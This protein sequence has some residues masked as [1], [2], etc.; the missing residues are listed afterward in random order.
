MAEGVSTSRQQ[1]PSA[2]GGHLEATKQS[3]GRILLEWGHVNV[4]SGTNRVTG[5]VLEKMEQGKG[6]W[7]A[8]G[9]IPP[10]KRSYM[11]ER[12]TPDTTTHYRISAENLYG[13]GQP[14]ETSA[15]VSAGSL[16]KFLHMFKYDWN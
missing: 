14:L 7:I 6:R 3:G 15:G 12:V 4:G 8:L 11:V 10:N 2:I 13:K 16:G 9:T 1:L 5:L